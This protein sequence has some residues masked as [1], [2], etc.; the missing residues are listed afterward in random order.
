[1]TM[2]LTEKDLIGQLEGFPLSVA[3]AMVNNQ[4]KQGN[5]ANI[6]VFQRKV[7]ASYME[8]GF[9]WNRTPEGQFFWSKVINGKQFPTSM[10][11]VK[12]TSE[13]TPVVK[14]SLIYGDTVTV[15]DNMRKVI[16]KFLCYTPEGNILAVTPEGFKQLSAGVNESYPRVMVYKMWEKKKD[17]VSEGKG[18]GV[19]PELIKIVS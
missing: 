13:E 14:E 11:E 9:S 1:M 6:G 16:R 18:V 8:G 4:V 5:P 12:G 10:E 19:D 17:Y 2:K 3:E 7:D 15:S